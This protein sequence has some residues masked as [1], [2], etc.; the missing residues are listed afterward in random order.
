VSNDAHRIG[1]NAHLLNL[2]GNYRSAGINWYIYHLLQN[3]IPSSDLTYTAFLS[4]PRARESFKHLTIAPSRLPTHNPVA[5]IF[6]EQIIQPIALRYEKIDV[7]HALAFAGPLAISIPWLATI[8]DLSFARFPQSFNRLN[9]MYLMWAV[10]NAVRRANCLIAISEST[11]R[12][13]V[14]LFGARPDHVKVIYCGVDSSFAPTQNQSDAAARAKMPA[15]MILHV[16][17]IEPRKNIAHLI[18]AFA[19]AKRAARLP[20]HLVLIGARG[21]KYTEVDQTIAQENCASDVIFPGYVPPAE[22]P[23]WYRAAEVFVYPSLYEGFGLPPL[24]AM[25]CGT[26]VISSNA[27]SLPEVVG[28]AA[29]QVAPDDQAALAEAMIRA[30]NDPSLREQM[31]ARGIAQAKNFSWARAGQETMALYRTILAEQRRGAKNVSA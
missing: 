26:P 16:G 27:A 6:W 2:A 3:L 19:Q 29:I 8:Y 31:S 4:E 9:R 15:K 25:A 13:L 7:L 1:L 20:H 30:L 28:E 10:K 11:K 12:D 22:L 21:W 23:A 24:E 17:T 5:R 18:R 14:K